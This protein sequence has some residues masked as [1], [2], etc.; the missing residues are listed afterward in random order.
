MQSHHN[1]LI[2]LIQ[3]VI[4]INNYALL[5]KQEVVQKS[6][7]QFLCTRYKLK[8]I[9]K[10]IYFLSNFFRHTYPCTPCGNST[11][12]VNQSF[13][14]RVITRT[15][16][17]DCGHRLSYKRWLIV[18]WLLLTSSKLCGC[19]IIYIIP[20]ITCGVVISIPYTS[21]Q[22]SILVYDIFKYITHTVRVFY[23]LLVRYNVVNVGKELPTGLYRVP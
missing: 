7:K 15:V 22:C 9:D 20:V 13:R 19:L 23:S 21:S 4:I 16:Q 17:D 1:R 5:L 6:K 8:C 12:I 11:N 2:V 3:F 14:D 10:R 18:F